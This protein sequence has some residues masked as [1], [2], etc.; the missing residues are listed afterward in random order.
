MSRGKDPQKSRT[1]MSFIELYHYG[2]I[3]HRLSTNSTS[4]C[5]IVGKKKKYRSFEFHSQVSELSWLIASTW[6]KHLTF[7]KIFVAAVEKFFFYNSI[8]SITSCSWSA[9]R[10]ATSKRSNSGSPWFMDFPSFCACSKSSQTNPL[11][12]LIGWESISFPEPTF[13]LVSTKTRSSGI[14]KVK[15]DK[16]TDKS[17]WLRINLVPRA[18]VLFGQHQDTELWNN[19]F[20]ET[21]ILGLPVSQ[22]MRG[23][24]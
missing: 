12:N 21:K 8:K 11:T 13:F 6:G 7:G 3:S 18:H 17:N 24:V 14:I 9:P 2:L 22:R 4:K 5:C 10:I 16:S 19:Q 15:P 1:P 23:L 20:P